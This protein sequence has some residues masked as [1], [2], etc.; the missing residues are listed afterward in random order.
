LSATLSYFCIDRH[1]GAINVLFWDRTVRKIGLKELWTLKWRP[2]FDTANRWTK[3][4]GVQPEDWPAWM[5]TF[6]D[7]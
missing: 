5:R 1:Q 2:Q 4:G 3:A 7:Y 6:K